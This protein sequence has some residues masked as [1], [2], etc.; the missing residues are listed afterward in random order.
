M[1]AQAG[2]C[3]RTNISV[4]YRGAANGGAVGCIGARRLGALVPQGL[5]VVRIIGM[6]RRVAEDAYLGCR[7]SSDNPA[8]GSHVVPGA[9]D[10]AC[11]CPC[12]VIAYRRCL[13]P[14]SKDQNC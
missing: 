4:G 13:S 2:Q 6:V 7:V 10:T 11:Y 9:S 5:Q 12:G 14:S 3:S 1:A 8:Q